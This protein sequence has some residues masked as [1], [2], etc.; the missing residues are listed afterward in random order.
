MK[1]R[2]QAA[3]RAIAEWRERRAIESD[4]PRGWILTDEVIYAL[5][6]TAPRSIAD[7]EAIRSLPPAVVRK[8]GEELL[9]LMRVAVESPDMANVQN[10][11]QRATPEENALVT[12]L[13]Q[14]VRNE[15]AA[16]EMS[17]EVIATRRDFE[18]LV[19]QDRG[20]P[21]VLRGWRRDVVGEKLLSALEK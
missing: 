2:E 12:R 19:F 18:A 8:R 5:A 15:A 13:Q 16:L 6:T 1:P 11:T 3:A 7:L 20:E 21:A 10:A 4:K 17:P 9:E 14:V